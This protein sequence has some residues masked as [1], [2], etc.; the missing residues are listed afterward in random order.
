MDFRESYIPVCNQQKYKK[1][2]KRLSCYNL[3]V[4]CD[5]ED[6]VKLK[7]LATFFRFSSRPGPG[8]SKLS[9]GPYSCRTLRPEGLILRGDPNGAD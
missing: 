7:R 9:H 5:P 2:G 1:I 3:P 8:E 4:L 6:L